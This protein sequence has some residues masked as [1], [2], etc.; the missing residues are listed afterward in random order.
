MREHS[1]KPDEMYE[2]LEAMFPNA[3]QV[4]AVRPPRRGPGGI[5]GNGIE[6]DFDQRAGL[7]AQQGLVGKSA[8]AEEEPPIRTFRFV[9]LERHLKAIKQA[10]GKIRHAFIPARRVRS[11]SSRDGAQPTPGAAKLQLGAKDD[12]GVS[13]AM[14]RQVAD[15][16]APRW[17]LDAFGAVRSRSRCGRSTA[18]GL[19][20]N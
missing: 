4:R 6:K 11:I 18:V 12:L 3:A 5:W 10:A 1:R 15:A 9:P 13:S 20:T 16:C 14:R 19:R 2:M 8:V 7:Q 17:I